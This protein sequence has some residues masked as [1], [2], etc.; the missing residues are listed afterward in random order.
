M[1]YSFTQLQENKTMLDYYGSI[2]KDN[3]EIDKELFNYFQN[4]DRYKMQRDIFQTILDELRETH[5]IKHSYSITG[6]QMYGGQDA[7]RNITTHLEDRRSKNLQRL[8]FAHAMKDTPLCEDLVE[9]I[10]NYTT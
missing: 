1:T 5:V 3:A 8:A 6:F 2:V 10:G 7:I 4:I 9:K